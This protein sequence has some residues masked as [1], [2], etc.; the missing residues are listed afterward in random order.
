MEGN[1]ILFILVLFPMIG[2]LTVYWAGC[3]KS[4]RRSEFQKWMAIAVGVIEFILMC[5]AAFLPG[6][7]ELMINEIC[8]RG[9]HLG[10]DGFR[11]L[12]G[13]VAAFMWMIT[14]CF[15]KEYLAHEKNTGRYYLF[16]LLT[17]GATVG[18]FLSE[19]LFTTFIFFEVMSFTSYVWVAQE[20]TSSALKAAETYLA[21]AVIGGMVLLMGLFLLDWQLG[22]L[23][24]SE[25]LAAASACEN[26]ELLYIAGGCTLFGFGAKAGAFPLHIWLP[27]AHPV[28]PAP[29]SA[30]LSG[31]L[32][33]SGIFGILVVSC[34]IF[35]YDVRWGILLLVLGIFTMFGG[36]LLA[37]F[38][39][40]LKRTLACSSMS[41]IGFVLLGIG[42]Q[43]ILGEENALAVR[44][45][46][47]HMVNHSLIKLVL[48]LAAGVVV[49][50]I[51]ELNLNDI[52]GF[53]RKK[54]LLN[55]IFLTGALGI[56]GIPLWNGYVSKTLLHESIVEGIAK[57]SG[58][59]DGFMTGF[60]K[61][62]EWI[63]L[64]SGGMTLAYMTKL[65]IAV[66]VEKNKDAVKQK[67]FDEGREYMK[68]LSS[69]VL[70]LSA[71]L[72]PMMGLFPNFVMDGIADWG[73]GFMHMDGKM[74]AV[75]YF[76]LENLKGAAI[77]IGIGI[78]LYF[79]IR[80]FLMTEKN[81]AGEYKDCWPKWM[82]L[83]ELFYRPV[84]LKILPFVCGVVCRILDSLVDGCILLLRRTVY[85]DRK[86]PHEL[87]E[88]S[89]FT[90]ILGSILDW[91]RAA[92]RKILH[93][94]APDHEVSYEHKL[95]VRREKIAETNTIIQRS[96]SFG[97]L[98]FYVGLV[99]TLVYLL[100]LGNA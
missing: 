51:H 8:G 83:E 75:S 82:D 86:I 58:L 13:M 3:S 88:G 76:N 57:F 2:A 23:E 20:E 54:P 18:V 1:I 94:P 24:M 80:R 28:A 98:L 69:I 56:S 34:N 93:Q 68:P 65:Y 9:I 41:Q 6:K 39:V 22:T 33:K 85:K 12:Y 21:V 42:M 32:T 72:L 97:L 37:I 30:L 73:Q 47:L 91:F 16:Q 84:L 87:A 14:L 15:S 10:M 99:F 29:A 46:L 43:C 64:I 55:C 95:A 70:T 35:L 44:G 66:F 92:K 81:G 11:G 90:H 61:L 50:N 77:S 59:S 17:L 48:F 52:R 49:M 40:D 53:G 62:T 78:L 31:I 25:L 27:K 60:L 45:T 96:L 5:Y 67:K 79:G 19:D 63:F 7:Q 26:K 38:S 71:V 89:E 4:K 74:H 36:A 100:Y